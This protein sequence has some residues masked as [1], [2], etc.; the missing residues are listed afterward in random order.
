M[1]F[2]GFQHGLVLR[3]LVLWFRVLLFYKEHRGWRR[4]LSGCVSALGAARGVPG[5]GLHHL[6]AHSP[7]PPVCQSKLGIL[8]CRVGMLPPREEGSRAE[9]RV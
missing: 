2:I 8:K 3:A 4:I 9:F 6:L 1:D 7:V 5:G